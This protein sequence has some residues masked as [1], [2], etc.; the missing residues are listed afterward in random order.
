MLT[1][2]CWSRSQ[3]GTGVTPFGDATQVLRDYERAMQVFESITTWCGLN[4]Q[5]FR[6]GVC[7]NIRHEQGRVQ[8]NLVEVERVVDGDLVHLTY[9]S[10]PWDYMHV[11]FSTLDRTFVERVKR[12]FI[13]FGRGAGRCANAPRDLPEVLRNPPYYVYVL[14]GRLPAPTRRLKAPQATAVAPSPSL[15]SLVD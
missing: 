1:M 12:Q 7:D 5:A 14:T 13:D 4:G 6:I 2:R 8:A 15:L 11:V 3:R 10:K 9:V